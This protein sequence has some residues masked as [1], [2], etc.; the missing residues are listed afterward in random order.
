MYIFCV[1]IGISPVYEMS[2]IMDVFFGYSVTFFCDFNLIKILEFL[3]D[4]CFRLN[5]NS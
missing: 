5:V 4:I 2:K 3:V 1:V